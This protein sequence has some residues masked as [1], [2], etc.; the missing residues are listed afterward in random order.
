MNRAKALALIRANRL[1]EAMALLESCCEEKPEDFDSWFRLGAACGKAGDHGKAAEA[2]SIAARLRPGSVP[3]LK[4]LTVALRHAGRFDETI[5]CCERLVQLAPRDLKNR[6]N[7]ATLRMRRCEYGKAIEQYREIL[8]MAPGFR[9]IHLNLGGALSG[10]GK[11]EEALQIYRE[12][13]ARNPRDPGLHSNVLLELLYVPGQLPEQL[14]YAHKAWGE[15]FSQ[16]VEVE[17]AFANDREARRRIRVG[18]VSGDFRTHSVAYFFEPLLKWRDTT[19]VEVFCYS[20]TI[21]CDATT[22]KLQALADHWVEI[23]DLGDDEVAARIRAD[24]IDILVDLAGHTAGGR[25]GLFLRRPAPV[26]ITYL[27][28]PSTTGVPSMDYRITDSIADPPGVEAFYTETLL[29]LPDCFLCYLPPAGAPEVGPLPA[30]ANGFVT[31]GSF[32]NLAKIN[33]TVLEAWA[34]LLNAVPHSRLLIKNYSLADAESRRRLLT[35]FQERGVGRDRIDLHGMVRETAEHLALYNRIDIA[36]D[37]F[38]YNGTTTTCEALW[39]GVPVVSLRG[40]CHSGRVGQSLLTCVGL[41]DLVAVSPEDYLA[42][43]LDLATNPDRLTHLRSSLRERMQASPLMD[44]ER[45][46]QDLEMALREC[47][48]RWCSDQK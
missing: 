20:H 30:L 27:G 34:S 8:R 36:L 6:A 48:E 1:P 4:N 32:N 46:V 42:R 41:A 31:F 11:S 43:C 9:G 33:P 38:P 35:F 23:R 10:Q 16:A 7:L 26:Q 18:Y 21:Q 44:G 15:L 47:W 29:R 40:P 5:A 3:T 28:Y 24:R 45:L 37:T 13:L 17:R 22:A 39:M 12:G 2:L 25:L 14:Y 19:A